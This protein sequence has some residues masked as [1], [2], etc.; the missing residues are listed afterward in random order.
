MKGG[1]SR[2]VF[3]YCFI[4]LICTDA[5]SKEYPA[6]HFDV[7]NGLPSNTIY[8]IYQDKDGLIW[9]GT[10]KG[11]ARYNG[12]RFEVFTT[13]DG[14]SDNECFFFKPDYS[15]RLW[16][17]TSN[18]EL[19]FYKD[20]VFHNASN[21]PYLN[22]G[23]KASMTLS[24]NVHKDSSVTFLL[25]DDPGF[26]EIKGEKMTHFSDP[27]MEREI[28]G[29]HF[30]YMN[31]IGDQRYEF[32]YSGKKV[33][34]DFKKNSNQD[35]VYNN[36]QLERM[37]A[38]KNNLF[39]LS[40]MNQLIDE[41]LRR[42][43]FISPDLLKDRFIYKI[44][45][46]NGPTVL[47]TN[48]GVVFDE[49]TVL[50][51]DFDIHSVIK[52]DNNS[53]WI[54]T[55]KNGVYRVSTDFLQQERIAIE[56]KQPVIFA[57]KNKDE[58][59]YTCNDRN[60]FS[61]NLETK[62]VKQL[63]DFQ[64]LTNERSKVK[65]VHWVEG[66]DYFNF[67]KDHNYKISGFDGSAQ[68]K[69]RRLELGNIW[70]TYKTFVSSGFR[71][72]LNT[73]SIYYYNQQAFKTSF[74][75]LQQRSVVKLRS[76]I[77]GSS[78]DAK[79]VIWFSQINGVYK[80][81]DTIA[82]PQ[83]QFAD[84]AFREIV[85]ANNCIVGITHQNKLII[86]NDYE[87]GKV[88][89]TTMTSNN[90]MW[91]K[92]Y[93]IND[94]SLLIS[95]NNFFR[96]LTIA[97]SKNGFTYNLQP[98]ENPYIPYQ[99]N[100]VLADGD[101]CYFFKNNAISS[102]PVAT[103]FE[104]NPIPKLRFSTIKTNETS[105]YI[106]DTVRL[107]YAEAQN[108]RVIFSA[109]SYNNNNLIYEYSITKDG[110]KKEW[111]VID[112]DELNLAKSGYGSFT[113]Q[114][115]AKNLAGVYSV[116]AS[117]LLMIKKPYWATFW[118]IAGCSIVLILGLVYL[119]RWWFRLKIKKKESEIRFLK[120]E[121]KALNA[122]M[123]PHFIFNSLNSV[124]GL[125]NNMEIPAAN[126]YIRIFSDLIRQNMHNISNEL[127]SLDDEMDLV[128]NYIKI[129]QLRMNEMLEYAINIEEG[130]D[131][132]EIMVPPLLIQPLVEN[133]IK[134]GIWPDEYKKGVLQ[135]NIFE[136]GENLL[137]EIIDNGA[138]LVNKS[139]S[140]TL[141]KSYAMGNIEKRL[142]QLSIIHN[143]KITVSINEILAIDGSVLGVK[144]L[145]TIRQKN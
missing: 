29:T 112:G 51:E 111:F 138:G 124:Q 65:S 142:E 104:R 10:D 85:F 69:I 107:N 115:R 114:V 83:A 34:Y 11:V 101:R 8:D 20:G 33:I 72:F 93:K 28:N 122:L 133:A 136:K 55:S 30:W 12:Q 125:V 4:F 67:A 100:Y 42:S 60:T 141:H 126:K 68:L 113:V 87:G 44:Y 105:L 116:P 137:V 120:S 145:V 39:F 59:L 73:N 62:A 31:K 99:P 88:V 37:I 144:S 49:H 106:K 81:K 77:Y 79:G 7:E 127:I 58:I 35:V 91:D 16:I 95:T 86:S 48:K 47:A 130:V 71:Y 5:Y 94:T 9:I 19:C 38:S 102:F 14:L 57:H 117:F 98:L 108:I 80:I 1:F 3:L 50:F 110:E 84:L 109:I 96:I 139:K 82:I 121:Y 43:D 52:D 132:D 17:A 129:E 61:L 75:S 97:T 6:Q 63:F 26:Y 46:E 128:E 103:L 135:I 89:F 92:F 13:N 27:K 41:N 123:N 64:K 25:F 40:N 22:L 23:N 56:A 134:H 66:H 90:C 36:F 53:Y 119:I 45:N 70:G 143:T 24:T 32:Y 15:G 21:T 2:I 140:D 118:F 78:V 131:S 18:G 54:G 74:D 76:K